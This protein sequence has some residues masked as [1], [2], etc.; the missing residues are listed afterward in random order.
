MLIRSFQQ[1]P[2]VPFLFEHIIS[3]APLTKRGWIFQEHYL[4][5]RTL[6][7]A[8]GFVLFE[9]NTLTA[10]EHDKDGQVY[11]IKPKLH[12]AADIVEVEKHIDQ[13]TPKPPNY[14]R[15][16]RLS[17]KRSA[18]KGWEGRRTTNSWWAAQQDKRGAMLNASARIGIRGA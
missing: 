4:V 2:K 6:H 8:G 9:Y 15:M 17:H 10:T 13:W 16:I 3:K 12:L 1:P 7:F 18:R 14:D 5:S 11:R